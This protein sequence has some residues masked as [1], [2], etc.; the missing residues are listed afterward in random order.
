M[1][2]TG[3]CKHV[4]LFTMY[5]G[6]P[7]GSYGKESP[8]NAGDLSSIPGLGRSPGGGHGSPF[9]YSYLEN[10]HRQRNLMGYGPF[11]SKELDITD[12]L[13]THNIYICIQNIS[14]QF[15][16]FQ[17]LSHV[18]LIVTPWTAARQAS[19]SIT[20]SQ[21]LLKLMSIELV[22]PPNHLVLC[23]PLL[24]LTMVCNTPKTTV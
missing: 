4:E 22:M 14:V 6:F 2:I 18:R 17:T 20:N 1:F 13:S 5:M 19:L 10:P 21:S 11:C 9:Q 15:S 16:S 12:Q 7:G 3:V 24:L 8:C 23:R